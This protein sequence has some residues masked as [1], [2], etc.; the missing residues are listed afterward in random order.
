MAKMNWS[1]CRMQVA[2]G[3]NGYTVF[4]IP[5]FWYFNGKKH[6]RAASVTQIKDEYYR[7]KIMK[8]LIQTDIGG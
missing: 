5:R 3:R 8:G 6:K 7:E 2:M 1:R 4:S